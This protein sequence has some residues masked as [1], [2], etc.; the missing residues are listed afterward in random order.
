MTQ[1]LGIVHVLMAGQPSE[2]R[3]AQKTRQPMPAILAGTRVG[4]PVS[5]RAGQV[6]RVIQFTA[7]WQSSIGGNRRTAKSEHQAAIEIKP[8]SAYIRVTRRVRHCRS[9]RHGMKC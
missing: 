4:Q 8:Q 2:H 3:L 9:G 5:R 1:P 6:Q 7:S